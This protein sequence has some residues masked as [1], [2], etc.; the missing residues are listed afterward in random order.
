MFSD[1]DRHKLVLE[2]HSISNKIAQDKYNERLLQIITEIKDCTGK[3]LSH[4]LLPNK[5]SR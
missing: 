5:K 1:A 3:D 4:I 2:I